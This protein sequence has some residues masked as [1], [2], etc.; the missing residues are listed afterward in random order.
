MKGVIRG[1]GL[2]AAFALTVTLAAA[3]WEFAQNDRYQ[4]VRADNHTLYK[5]DKATGKTWVITYSTEREIHPPMKTQASVQDQPPEIAPSKPHLDAH[6]KHPRDLLEGMIPTP[7][8]SGPEYT[9]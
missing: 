6:T 7:S 8:A 2:A 4:L 9:P 5:L 1:I 3:L